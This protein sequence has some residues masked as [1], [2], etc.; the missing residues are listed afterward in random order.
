MH[1]SHRDQGKAQP[2]SQAVDLS[3][4]FRLEVGADGLQ[5]AL[6]ACDGLLVQRAN[7]A[8]ELGGDQQRGERRER[9]GALRAQ[10]ERARKLPVLLGRPA[11]KL[12][13]RSG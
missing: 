1:C 2:T 11:P 5:G 10:P 4:G 6:K 13:T 8:S 9:L 7:R 3:V 12:E